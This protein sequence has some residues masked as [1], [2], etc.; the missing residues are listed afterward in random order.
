[1]YFQIVQMAVLAYLAFHQYAV[2]IHIMAM[3]LE[4]LAW[5]F[6]GLIF[7]KVSAAKLK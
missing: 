2:L 3:V 7:K 6:T 1:M 5:K 4:Q